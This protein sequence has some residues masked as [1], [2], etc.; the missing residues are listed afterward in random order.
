MSILTKNKKV[1][2]SKRL[3]EEVSSNDV[4]FVSFDGLDFGKIQSLRNKLKEVKANFKVIRNSVIYFA[5]KDANIL[6]DSKKPNFL[7]GPTAVIFIKNQDE[8]SSVSKVLIDFA[9]ENPNLR[10]K[11]GFVSKDQIT[12]DFVKEL[13]KL[14]SKK[15]IV[16]KIASSLYTSLSNMRSVIEAPIRDL[17]YVLEAVKKKKE[18][19]K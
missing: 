10:I 18:E 3:I 15:D 4:I 6:K 1:E 12:P 14:G 5:I 19:L 17:V 11:G 7:K 16:F 2:L 9:K 8:I 13:S